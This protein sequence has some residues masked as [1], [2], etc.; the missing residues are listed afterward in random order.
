MRRVLISHARRRLASIHGGGGLHVPVV[1]ESDA[2]ERAG[3]DGLASFAETR[4]SML[5]DL[6]RA[7]DELAGL[8][9]RHHEVVELRFFGGMSVDEVALATGRS[10]ASVKRDWR[11]ARAWLYTRLND[12]GPETAA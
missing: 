4:A 2:S 3:Q 11:R 6:D 7:M 12:G 9:R 5:L 1:R 8:S 10:T